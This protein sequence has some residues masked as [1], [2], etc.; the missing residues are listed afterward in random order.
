VKANYDDCFVTRASKTGRFEGSG[1]FG[2]KVIF[3]AIKRGVLG[4][5]FL[6]NV[7]EGD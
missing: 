2:S 4:L 5:L 6:D 1:V 3:N 7:I